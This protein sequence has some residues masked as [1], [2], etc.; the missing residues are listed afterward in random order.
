MRITAR[1]KRIEQ[2]L[3]A[4]TERATA[5]I[6][7]A[8]A[9][10]TAAAAAATTAS[11]TLSAANT[12]GGGSADEVSGDAAASWRA[13]LQPSV[14]DKRKKQPEHQL[15]QRQRT[16]LGMFDPNRNDVDVEEKRAAEATVAEAEE[17]RRHEVRQ[18]L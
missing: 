5:A 17:E 9:A 2:A 16:V 15:D 4:E 8:A 10:A 6:A 14:G 7:A 12:A 11:K 1:L 18:R 13:L 3:A